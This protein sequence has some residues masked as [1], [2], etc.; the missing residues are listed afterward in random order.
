MKAVISDSIQEAKA[1]LQNGDVVAIPTE[2]VYGLAANALN[3][4]AVAKIFEAKNRP[5]FDPLIV[6][7]ASVEE[8]EKYVQAIPAPLL[9]LMQTFSPGPLTVLL[10]KKD[11]IPDIVTSGLD[12]VGIRI[13][14]H[15][16]TLELLTALD[17]P[18][19]APSAN[20]F[21]YVSPTSAQHV[22]NQLADRIPYILDGGKC[23]V[24]VES[25]IVGMEDNEVVVYRLGGIAIEEIEKIAGKVKLTISQGSNPKA[26]GMLDVHY[27][28]S[29]QLYV[30]DVHS[31]ATQ[32]Q[33]LRLGL[34][35]FSDA[36]PDY[37]FIQRN[38]LS[39]TGNL[40]E[41]AANLFEALR[42]F[43]GKNIDI[44]IAET[45]PEEGLG[46]AINDRLRRAST[47]QNT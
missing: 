37:P 21:G 13:P 9:R 15:P 39:P 18:L 29:T 17:F 7:V 40:N 34:I 23:S 19:C 10:K 38:V 32:F 5:F 4:T 12:T 28:P 30:G 42:S 46:R 24:G 11:V 8:A 25:T 27:A 22:F 44:I 41:A 33:A 45:F 26:P 43:D 1:L 2:T 36:Y 6:H 16:L 35:S 20:P 31:L 47:K 14:N 3:A